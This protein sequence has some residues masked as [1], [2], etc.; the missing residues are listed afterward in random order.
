M[1]RGDHK[2]HKYTYFDDLY[3][4]QVCGL[5]AWKNSKVVYML[6]SKCISAESSN[7]CTIVHVVRCLEIL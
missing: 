2:F 4:A 5:V 1:E 7:N 3:Q 6:T